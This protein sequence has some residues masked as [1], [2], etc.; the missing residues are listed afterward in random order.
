M[1]PIS[2][3]T[4]S[5]K[6]ALADLPVEFGIRFKAGARVDLPVELKYFRNS[7]LFVALFVFDGTVAVLLC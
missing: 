1:V 7:V 3:H 2:A 6:L 4:G 5:F